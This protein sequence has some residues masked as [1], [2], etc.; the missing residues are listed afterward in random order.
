MTFEELN[1]I[2]K[3]YFEKFNTAD[4]IKENCIPLCPF[5]CERIKISKTIWTGRY[6][7]DLYFERNLKPNL[8]LRDRVFK[9]ASW[10]YIKK[11][12]LK[13]NV[14]YESLSYTSIA[15][16]ESMTIVDLL[17]NFGYFPIYYSFFHKNL[18]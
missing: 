3:F 9:N 11:S 6:P 10:D 2:F 4:Y 5:E 12:I 15:E 16:N 1:C 17:S 8:E 7:A 18:K 14:Y 13:L